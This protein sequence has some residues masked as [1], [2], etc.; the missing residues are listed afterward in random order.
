[1]YYAIFIN[2]FL[3]VG[4]VPARQP[5]HLEVSRNWT[6]VG[7]MF[8]LIS[9]LKYA[10]VCLKINYVFTGSE[11]EAH[12]SGGAGYGFAVVGANG[13]FHLRFGEVEK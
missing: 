7:G 1:M 8:L 13:Y 10:I 11:G 5:C 4:S 12:S 3:R 9:V 6:G 2:F